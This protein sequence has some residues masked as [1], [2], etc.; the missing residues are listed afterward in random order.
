MPI[1]VTDN[2]SQNFKTRGG[3]LEVLREI[4]LQV[5]A[6]EIVAVMGSSGCGKSTLLLACGVMRKPTA[7]RIVMDGRDV[8]QWS[9]AD[10]N[11][12]RSERIGYLF[13]TLELIPYLSVL[14][15]VR[16]VRGTTKDQADELLVLLGLM[17]LANRKPSAVSQGQR[18]RAALARALV[19][20][21][22]LLIADEPTGNLDEETSQVV[23][24]TLRDF[25]DRG[26][27]VLL[28][29]HDPLGKQVAD[30]VYRMVEGQL[31]IEE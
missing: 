28:A 14:E 4:N 11:R 24:K 29:T 10:Q 22:G 3:C 13:Q 27:A 9:L 25:A 20:Q 12:L 1:L 31:E 21:P 19:H 30:R 8:S 15:N 16:L 2:L 6:N 5:A 7:G 17:D 26:G 23:F 18:Q